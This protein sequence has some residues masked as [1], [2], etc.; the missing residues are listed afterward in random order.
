M[1]IVYKM[2]DWSTHCKVLQCTLLPLA[3]DYLAECFIEAYILD[4]Y[5]CAEVV[6]AL[7]CL[8]VGNV[9]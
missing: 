4:T 5:S 9:L 3:I 1:C 2:S 8:A 7:C 6:F